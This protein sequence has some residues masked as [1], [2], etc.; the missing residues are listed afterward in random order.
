MKTRVPRRVIV[1]RHPA[2]TGGEGAYSQE[3][4]EVLCMMLG[5]I[6]VWLDELECYSLAPGDALWFEF[7]IGRRFFNTSKDE[8]AVVLCANTPPIF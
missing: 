2:G 5:Q 6:E 7:E 4:E 1:S 8:T 3:G